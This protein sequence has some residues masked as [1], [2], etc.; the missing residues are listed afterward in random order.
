LRRFEVRPSEEWPDRVY[1]DKEQ[2]DRM[3]DLSSKAS[4]AERE[5]P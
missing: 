3:H 4:E 5:V 2:F 1:V